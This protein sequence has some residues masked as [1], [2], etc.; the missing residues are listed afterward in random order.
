ML[1]DYQNELN[2]AQYQAVTTTE[3]PVLVIAGAGSGKTRTIVYRLAYLAE[4]GIP[5]SSILLLTFTRKASQEMLMRAG[6]L[7]GMGM[8]CV[9][10]GTFH[11]FAYAMLRSYAH[12]LGYENGFSVLDRGD[13][14]DL[15]KQA[16]DDLD[17]SKGDRSFPKKS[18]ILG[19]LSQARNKELD[20]GDVLRKEAYH[21]DIYREDL[22]RLGTR[23]QE[24]KHEFRVLD[25]D[26]LLFILEDLLRKNPDILELERKHFQYIMVDEYQDTNRVQAR[27]IK[28]LAGKS[29]NVMAVGDDA[30]SIYAFRGADIQNIL[31]FPDHF[32]GTTVIKLEQNYRSVQPI[33]SLTN[34]ILAGSQKQYAKKLF[35]E[36]TDTLLPEIIKPMSDF[37][38]AKLV[39]SKIL[40]LEQRFPLHEIAV[41]FRSGYHS[42]SLEVELNK[43]GV[44]FQKFG[45]LKFSDAAHIKDALSFM[46]LTANGLDLPSFKRAFSGVKGVG[47][48]TC[49]R[50]FQAVSHGDTEAIARAC[51]KNDQIQCVMKLLDGL[52][53]RTLTPAQALDAIFD[54]YKPVVQKRFPDDYPRRIAGLDQLAQIA[55]PYN[56]IDT[57]LAELM[58]DNPEQLGM[59]NVPQDKLVL[60]TV[61]SSKGL[62]WSAVM[63]ISLVE[64]RFPSKH[65]MSSAEEFEEERRLLY[66]ACTR[67]RDYLGLFVPNS[68]YNRFQQGNDP[69]MP[70]PFLQDIPKELFHEFKET[71]SGGLSKTCMPMAPSQT[72]FPNPG[73]PQHSTPT[74][75]GG[76]KT[77]YCV[78]KIFG[79]GKIVG[80][81]PPNKYKINFPG[82]GLKMIVE[83]YVEVEN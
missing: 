48:K 83:D 17:L 32:P 78:H 46:K 39:V 59:E 60:S 47:P 58:L 67:A 70:C 42:Y 21:L 45:G 51:K 10:G 44:P 11:G 61:H 9:S 19:L 41:L 56:D 52:R 63:V 81:V 68:V 26:D 72:A 8:Q 3:G 79:R 54:Y 37:T 77:G 13:A 74:H 27:L 64:E 49:E 35:S 2:P 16:R 5:L 36:R 28:L 73:T 43:Q 30:Q 34:A 14:E 40:E 75:G 12:L 57:F 50:L 18:T 33:L 1:I 4:Q 6:E 53:E 55:A 29:G 71:Y 20:L 62:E 25:Y 66:V 7:T 69:A 76:G 23:Y 24:L 82:F 38:E 22:I 80:H 65:A 31:D 15:I